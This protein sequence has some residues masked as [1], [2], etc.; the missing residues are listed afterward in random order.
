MPK[1]LNDDPEF[2]E[3]QIERKK[4][5]AAWYKQYA[6]LEEGEPVDFDNLD[7]WALKAAG[8]KGRCSV[9]EIQEAL[10]ESMLT[11]APTAEVK[12]QTLKQAAEQ[13]GATQ[14]A[15]K[16]QI[17]EALDR[18]LKVA[19]RKQGQRGV[20]YPNVLFFGE[21]GTGKT[22]ICRA[23]AAANGINLVE[24]R[25]SALDPTDIGG[26]FA[27]PE[28]GS[29]RARK[30]STGEF[31]QLEQPNSVLF[32]DE[33][34]RANRAVRGALLEL[35]NSHYIPD[36]S[37]PGGQRFLPNFLFTIATANPPSGTYN[38][39]E[40]DP[41][42]ISRFRNINIVNDNAY[43]LRYLTNNLYAE[44]LKRAENRGD[45]EEILEI[46]G[47]IEL[48]KTLLGDK[49]FAFDDAEDLRKGYDKYESTFKPLNYRSFTE[50]LDQCDGTK[51][52]FLDLWNDFAN[53]DKKRMAEGILENYIDVEDKANEV[54]K[55][56]T[57]SPVF[58]SSKRTMDILRDKYPEI[59]Q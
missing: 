19:R 41:A 46:K 48:A 34:N 45:E 16:G 17:E 27:P 20:S 1:R 22:S 18:A 47:K 52:D 42:E 58:K 12:N 54:L 10:Q 31:D 44:E 36:S 43:I 14:V 25:A 23:W 7:Q 32:L 56:Q 15:G 35:V 5:R 9:E 2:I 21:A 26:L 37:V 55:T 28:K 33:F 51:R 11:E 30:V 24:V 6:G 29:N 49:R 53:P 57:N 38:V 3:D 50:L 8:C 40:L 59:N 39:D 13:V 4:R